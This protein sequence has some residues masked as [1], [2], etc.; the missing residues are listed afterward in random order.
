MGFFDK[1]RAGMKAVSSGLRIGKKVYN[2]FKGDSGGR[3]GSKASTQ[4][5]DAKSFSNEDFKQPESQSEEPQQRQQPM[6]RGLQT[7]GTIRRVSQ[8]VKAVKNEIKLTKTLL[9]GKDDKEKVATIKR[10]KERVKLQAEAPS[11]RSFKKTAKEQRALQ[12]AQ[13]VGS[14]SKK[15]FKKFQKQQEKASKKK[16]LK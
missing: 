12:Q 4:S 15:E 9:E 2:F 3:V 11:K 1:I 14:M 7:A 8:G 5:P 10:Q 16:K 13:L 6:A